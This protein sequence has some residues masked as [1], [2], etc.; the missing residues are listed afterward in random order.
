MYLHL[1]SQSGYLNRL[2]FRSRHFL[3]VFTGLL[4]SKRRTLSYLRIISR[5]CRGRISMPISH[6]QLLKRWYCSAKD[7]DHSVLGGYGG[8]G[9][10][11]LANL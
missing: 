2:Q 5:C 8:L 11:C 1:R 9:F 7:L 6:W 10:E 4:P 3:V